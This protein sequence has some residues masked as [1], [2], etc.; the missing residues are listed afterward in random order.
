MAM[1]TNLK[2]GKYWGEMGVDYWD[3]RIWSQHVDNFEEMMLEKQEAAASASEEEES[4]TLTQ[5]EICASSIRL[6]SGY[7]TAKPSKKTPATPT[8]H[9]ETEQLKQQVENLLQYNESREI[10]FEAQKE[11]IHQLKSMLAIV[12]EKVEE[13]PLHEPSNVEDGNNS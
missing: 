12:L 11:E 9:S 4:S 10:V 7:F 3:A 8:N 5:K 2:V 13:K 1:H 6:K